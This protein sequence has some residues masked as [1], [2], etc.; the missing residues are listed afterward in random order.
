MCHNEGGGSV[1]NTETLHDF[2]CSGLN[3]HN[4]HSLQAQIFAKNQETIKYG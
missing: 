1:K 3:I 2:H 4:Q